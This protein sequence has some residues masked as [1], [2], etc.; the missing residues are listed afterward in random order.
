[1]QTVPALVPAVVH[2]TAVA[3]GD[4]AALIK[5]GSGSG[6]SDLALRCLGL[7]AGPLTGQ[8]ARLVSDDQVILTRQGQGLLLSAP[9][10]IAGR[11]EV[12]GVGIVDVGDV[13]P[14]WLALV[15][16]LVPPDVVERMPEERRCVIEGVEVP[17]VALTPF[18]ASAPLKLLLCLR[19]FNSRNP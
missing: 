2:G 14:A 6:K 8:A 16:E 17:V 13:T 19:R 5:G 12:R 4:V 15:I 10:S 11:L 1:M 9:A 3:L 7:P 18:E